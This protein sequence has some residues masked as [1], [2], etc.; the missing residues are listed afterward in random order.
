MTKREAMLKYVHEARRIPYYGMTFFDVLDEQAN[1][2]LIAV[3]E[4]GLFVFSSDTLSMQ[5]RLP[6]SQLTTWKKT[7]EGIEIIYSSTDGTE[8]ATEFLMDTVKKITINDL[9]NEY[10]FLLP[11]TYKRSDTKPS[12]EPSLMAR[13]EDYGPVIERSTLHRFQ[14]RLEYLKGFYM[15]ICSGNVIP[16]KQFCS[17]VDE[18]IDEEK[19]F[20]VLDLSKCR[21]SEKSLIAITKAFVGAFKYEPPREG[22]KVA[23]FWRNDIC[24]KEFYLAQNNLPHSC[25]KY[26]G[27]LLS[28]FSNLCI[29]DISGICLENIGAKELASTIAE[30]EYLQKMT[31]RDANIGNK[32]FAALVEA[33]KGKDTFQVVDASDNRI[34]DTNMMSF[35]PAYIKD[36]ISLVE[37]RL[38]SNNISTKGFESLVKCISTST[39]FQSLD[40]SDNPVTNR[41]C[42]AVGKLLKS[43]VSLRSFTWRNNRMMGDGL[44]QIMKAVR[45]AKTLLSLDLSSSYDTIQ[46]DKNM[47]TEYC[48]FLL[49]PQMRLRELRVASNVY[50]L[51]FSEHLAAALAKNKTL[52]ILDISDTLS[53]TKSGDLPPQWTDALTNN[54]TLK[55]LHVCQNDMGG[56]GFRT[57]FR[58]LE[59]NRTL[60]E[61]YASDN[62]LPLSSMNDLQRF[63]EKTSLEKL[64]LQKCELGD[65]HLKSILEGF[66]SAP[67]LNTLDIRGNKFSSDSFVRLFHGLK[68]SKSRKTLFINVSIGEQAKYKVFTECFVEIEH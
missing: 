13:P 38:A 49:E 26:L 3:A 36:N 63:F 28:Y 16:V 11:G 6:F 24:I 42:K 25:V 37:I 65:K 31:M 23:S 39:T 43:S 27:L 17:Q 40:L 55:T 67:L 2:F 12:G 29:L 57:M 8:C 9:L 1:P 33:T 20:T 58:A 4:D 44:L 53:C 52:K 7:L 30:M 62:E 51:R 21:I 60:M 46:F 41:S 18:A 15:Q 54:T 19:D 45:S 34:G 66:I 47:A 10:Y 35:L 50:G 14:S 5:L 48:K 56:L 32:G 22:G 64:D 68:R 59:K 61:L